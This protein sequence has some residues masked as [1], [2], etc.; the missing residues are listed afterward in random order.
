MRRGELPEEFNHTAFNFLIRGPRKGGETVPENLPWVPMNFWESLMALGDLEEFGK[1]PADMQEAPQRFQE[2]YNHVTPEIE[3][4][5]LDWSGL[6]KTPFLKLLVVRCLRPDRLN[7]ATDNW[8]RG[9][10]PEGPRY[11]DS[12]STLN[13]YQ[14]LEESLADS[15]PTVPIYFIL[16]PGADVVQD[17]DRAAD[18]RGLEKNVSYHNISMGQGQDIVAMHCLDMGHK[19]GHWTILNNVHL[20]PVWLIELEKKL[21]SF[22]IEGSH[23]RMR[24]FLSSEPSNAIP[25]GI[26]ARCIKLTNEPPAGLRANMKRAW[27][28][29]D[30]EMIDESDGKLKGIIF[31]LCVFHSVLLER[32]RFGSKGY[33][34][35]YPFSLGDLRD[36]TIVLQN[37]ME[38]APS[39]IP[40][41]DLRYLFGEITYGGH[42]VNDFDRLLANTYLE[43]YMKDELFDEME[44]YPFADDE[45][46]SFKAPSPTTFDRY[47]AYVDTELTV[48]TT[49]AFGLHPNAEIGF[50]TENSLALYATL[51]ELQ[52]R[53]GG[54]GEGGMSPQAVAENC[55]ND[56]MD[57]VQETRFDMDD[58]DAQLEEKGPYQNVFIQECTWMNLLLNEIR[59]SLVELNLGF[60]GELTMSDSMDNLMTSLFLDKIPEGWHAI[61][62]PSQRNLGQWLI[63]FNL[64]IA[65]ITDWTTNPSG[66]PK[67][68]WLSGMVNP[69]S[70]L[71]AI[72]QVTAQNM[73]AELDKLCIQTDITKKKVK[74][75][76]SGSRGALIRTASGN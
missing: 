39:K 68:T 29:F 34:M 33:N 46:E 66:I 69:Q 72:K 4:L 62:W 8:I 70:F 2:W 75:I 45:K 10:M 76:D 15:A 1:L 16:S 28:S 74:D 53:E 24:V 44:L 54:S 73:G 36:S 13:A 47:A 50:R 63:N 17:V 14:I 57:K 67:V 60:A 49:I 9:N 52:P 6:D 38:N 71:T 56:I 58:I 37:Y 43:H 55:M 21:D 22:N 64:R 11:A 7:M 25:I 59:R 40:W 30:K 31:G 48:E 23:E 65:Q 18:V 5:P 42:I 3:K 51:V 12:D 26:L 41:A 61:A 35:M 27:S 19:Q 20:M 32:K